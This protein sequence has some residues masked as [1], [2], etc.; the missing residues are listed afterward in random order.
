M[1]IKQRREVGFYCDT[2]L[3]IL[4][5][6][7]YQMCC[8]RAPG[9]QKMCDAYNAW[10]KQAQMALSKYQLGEISWVEFEEIIQSGPQ[11]TKAPCSKDFPPQGAFSFTNYR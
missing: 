6:F 7:H 9:N 3:L 11:T 4:C 8:A 2:L 10:R 1:Q 5:F